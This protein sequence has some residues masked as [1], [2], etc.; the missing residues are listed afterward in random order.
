MGPRLGTALVLALASGAAVGC[1]TTPLSQRWEWN[2]PEGFPEPRIPEDNP[3]TNAK[4]DLG[5][6]LFYDVRLSG[7]QTESCGTCHRQE[8][9]FTD[10]LA[11]ALGSLGDAHPRSSMALPNVAYQATLTWAN[12]AVRRLEDQALLPMFGEDPIVELGLAGM[13]DVLLQRLRDDDLY[14]TMFAEAFP[15]D[16]DPIQLVNVTAAIG[17]FERGLI[18]GDSPYDRYVRGEVDA[19]SES[20]LR[21]AD[22]FFGER[23]DCFHCHGGFNFSSSVDH[24]GVVFQEAV[25]FNNGLYDIDGRG[26]YPPDNRGLAAFTGEVTDEG[27]FKPP[28]LRNIAVTAPYMHDG[29]IATLDE[30]IDMYAAGGRLLTEGPYVGDGRENPYKSIFVHGFEPTAEERADLLA[31][32]VSLT[33][34][35][36]LTNPRFG[37]PAE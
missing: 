32:L 16:P 33:D 7:N 34:D 5:R 19:M 21:G 12:P 2:L 3:M 20:A 8:L 17:C 23:F 18:S 9:A 29:S 26:G 1:D 4:F 11:N 25:F 15:D 30:V 6:R 28:S 22:L 31:F 10:G 37:P 27:R 35:A 36:F 24:A 13:E 14:P